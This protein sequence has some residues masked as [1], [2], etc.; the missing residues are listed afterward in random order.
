MSLHR[1]LVNLPF[2]FQIPLDWMVQGSAVARAHHRLTSELAAP[3]VQPIMRETLQESRKRVVDHFATQNTLV[4]LSRRDLRQVPWYV[5]E[6][7]ESGQLLAEITAFFMAWRDWFTD[8]P[9]TGTVRALLHNLLL[10]NP[11]GVRAMDWRLMVR[12][13]LEQSQHPQLAS[14][15]R[16]CKRFHLLEEKG[17]E[18]FAQEIMR[19]ERSFFALCQEAGLQGELLG[20]GFVRHSLDQLLQ[21]MGYYVASN[22]LSLSQLQTVLHGFRD[23]QGR[24]QQVVSGFSVRLAEVL[25]R[26][27]TERD[28]EEK[29]RLF[30]RDF[31]VKALGDPRTHPAAWQGVEP[32]IRDV[33]IGWLSGRPRRVDEKLWLFIQESNRQIGDLEGDFYHLKDHGPAAQPQRIHQALHRL[34]A[35][36]GV[37]S[38]FE[39]TQI[40]Q[41]GQGMVDILISL[42]DK[43]TLFSLST[44]DGLLVMLSSLRMAINELPGRALN[45]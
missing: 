31:L 40:V 20:Q 7:D 27:F 37:A 13:Q 10:H 3:G 18:L 22:D 2:P 8:K 44:I 26:P 19:G 45:K 21:L 16:R 33:L 34:N 38:F 39:L 1:A 41:T 14:D 43:R 25:L 17:A 4:G 11:Q 24:F 9:S 30:L 23:S 28:P 32:T 36:L 42:R 5:F 29:L 15:W 35:I 12:Q 6:T